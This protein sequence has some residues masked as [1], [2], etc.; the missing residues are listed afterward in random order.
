MPAMMERCSRAA[1]S[2]RRALMMRLVKGVSGKPCVSWPQ[3]KPAAERNRKPRLMVRITTANC[4]WPMMRRSTSGIEQ[5]AE[6]GHGQRRRAG[7]PASSSCPMVPM[8]VSA[9]KAPSIIR[10]PWAKFTIS[11]AL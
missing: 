3:M 2:R 1:G 4:G 7:S 11:V 8:K 10:S 9:T 6:H 5:I